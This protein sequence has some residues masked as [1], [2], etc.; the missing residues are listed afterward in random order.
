MIL[1]YGNELVTKMLQDIHVWMCTG[2]IYQ[3]SQFFEKYSLVN[4]K[5][6]KIKKLIKENFIPRRLCLFD[7]LELNESNMTVDIKEYPDTME[8][9][10]QSFVDR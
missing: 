3:A 9:I 2:D 7:N 5:F 4:E 8:G 1:C 6:L 10:I